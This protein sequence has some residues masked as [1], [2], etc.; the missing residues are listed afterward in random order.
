MVRL[1]NIETGHRLPQKLILWMIRLSSGDPHQPEDVVKTM[2][3]RPEFFGKPYST[4][5][6]AVMR[7]PSS[8]TVGERELFAAF[9]S[10]KNECQ[11]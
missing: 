7:G 1:R 6:Q 3:Y 10:R 9:T 8:W 5:L 11:F 4:L 2:L